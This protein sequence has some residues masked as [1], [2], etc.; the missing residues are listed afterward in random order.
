MKFFLERYGRVSSYLPISLVPCFGAIVFHSEV[1]FTF[2]WNGAKTVFFGLALVAYS[3]YNNLL[4]R[5]KICLDTHLSVS[6][7]YKTNCINEIWWMSCVSGIKSGSIASRLWDCLSGN[8][9]PY[10]Q[11]CCKSASHCNLLRSWEYSISAGYKVSHLR[12][13]S[14]VRRCK[15]SG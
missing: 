3:G 14:T 8:P 5:A 10:R 7:R 12:R 9:C 15:R 2:Y 13:P 4:K 1:S 6:V 11:C